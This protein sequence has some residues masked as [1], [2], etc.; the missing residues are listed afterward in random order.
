MTTALPAG[1]GSGGSC[2]GRGAALECRVSPW[3]GIVA[4]IV[5]TAA[6]AAAAGRVGVFSALGVF[7]V[8]PSVRSRW[9]KAGGGGP[10][11]FLSP[12]QD[13]N[14]DPAMGGG[15]GLEGK[16][17]QREREHRPASGYVKGFPGRWR[18]AASRL[19]DRQT[20]RH[21]GF[22]CLSCDYSSLAR[23]CDVSGGWSVASLHS[24]TRHTTRHDTRHAPRRCDGT[25]KQ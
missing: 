21:D 2:G 12:R 23:Q 5:W 7:C 10:L 9:G 18:L 13:K 6:A 11:F 22:L 15:G 16:E 4:V 19:T 20:D 14:P 25:D 3:M 17:R 1:K 8:R 24:T